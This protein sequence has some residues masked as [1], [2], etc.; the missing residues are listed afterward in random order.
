MFRTA[1]TAAAVTGAT[2][3]QIVDLDAASTAR[4]SLFHGDQTTG[5]ATLTTIRTVAGTG[6]PGDSDPVQ[7]ANPLSH[8]FS[9]PTGGSFNSGTGDYYVTD[10]G[11]NQIKRLNVDILGNIVDVDTVLRTVTTFES[12]VDKGEQISLALR[13]PGA[14]LVEA[15]GGYYFSDESN[16]RVIRYSPSLVGDDCLTMSPNSCDAHPMCTYDQ[17]QATC[18]SVPSFSTIFSIPQILFDCI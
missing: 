9:Y 17:V 8:H 16:H 6:I 14:I 10:T 2:A 5:R 13:N 3:M 12:R 7:G 11:S 4:A 15:D 18:L 1:V